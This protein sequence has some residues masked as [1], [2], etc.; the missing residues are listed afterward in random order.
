MKKFNVTGVCVPEEHYMVNTQEKQA[1]IMSL[2]EYGKYFTIN[3]ARQFGKTTM[4]MQLNRQLN[5]IPEYTCI[6]L[7]FEGMGD[8]MFS[9]DEAFCKE[10]LIQVSESLHLNSSDSADEWLDNSIKGF[11]SLG[12]HISKL[13]NGKKIVLLVDKVDATVNNKV[14]LRFLGMLRS[15][16]LKRAE[17]LANTFH[18]VILAGVHDIKNIKLKLISAELHNTQNEQEGEYNSPWNIATNFD[19]DMFFT[20]DEISTMLADYDNEHNVGMNI[21]SIAKEIFRFTSGYPYLVSRVCQYID[22]K[23]NQWTVEG[24]RD[25][26]KVISTERSVLKDD[27]FKNLENNKALY[28]FM[29]ELLIGE[30]RKKVALFD[31]IVERCIMYGFITVDSFGVAN[32]GNMIFEMAMTEYFISKENR[33]SAVAKQVCNGMYEEITRGGKFN[34]ELCLQKFA[35]HYDE[36]YS[37]ADETFLERHGRLIFLSFLR[38]LVNGVGFFHIES[39]FTDMRRMDVVVDYGRE[40]FIIEL[41]LWKGE[42]SQSRAYEQLLGYMDSR[43]LNKGYLLTFDFRKNENKERKSEWVS[44]DG[45]QIFEVIL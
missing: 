45:K 24:V 14:F 12:R 19:V 28:D 31:P 30:G 20:A 5:S 6:R 15:L 16:F 3:R 25:A 1:R 22:E 18:S 8:E 37:S 33:T 41:K 27:I 43:G 4:L 7:T 23:T 17:K 32:V 40:Q 26:V 21:S 10:F 2:I 34:M 38:P 11:S 13:C 42:K 35:E 9:D 36:I 29:Y 44:V 39:Q